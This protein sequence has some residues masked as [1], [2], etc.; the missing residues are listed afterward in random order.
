MSRKFSPDQ[1]TETA[2]E[3]AATITQ[4]GDIGKIESMEAQEQVAASDAEHNAGEDAP[5]ELGSAA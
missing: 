4:D 2:V 3:R 1:E 5:A